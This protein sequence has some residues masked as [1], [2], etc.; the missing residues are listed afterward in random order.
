MFMKATSEESMQYIVQYQRGYLDRA[1]NCKPRAL[2]LLTI[3]AHSQTLQHHDPLTSVVQSSLSGILC[4]KM[5]ALCPPA[6]RAPPCCYHPAPRIL[7]EALFQPVPRAQGK[8]P[9]TAPLAPRWE[10]PRRVIHG[11]SRHWQPRSVFC[12]LFTPKMNPNFIL[13]VVRCAT[14]HV[15]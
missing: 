13:E 5:L 6:G 2:T 9:R 15:L 4:T 3:S 11:G 10:E 1:G 7:L 12:T 8:Y 14:I